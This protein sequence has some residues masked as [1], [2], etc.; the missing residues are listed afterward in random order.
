[1]AK[2]AEEKW[3]TKGLPM[4]E[5]WSGARRGVPVYDTW[6]D[7]YK[8]ELE[9]HR[10][11]VILD[12]GC[13]TGANTL[14]LVERGFQ[15]LSADYS[16]E[17]LANVR[18]YIPGSRTE[19]VDMNRT[20]PF[21]DESFHIIVADISLHYFAESATVSLMGEIRRA[22]KPGGLLLARVSSMNDTYYGAGSGREIQTHFYDHGSYAQ[23]YFDEGDV[24]RFF[25][26]IGRCTYME[27]SMTRKE[28]YYS[29]PKML[30]QVKAEKTQN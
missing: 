14:Y 26:I 2:A 30:Y 22:L 10:D 7:G 12:L 5:G 19:Y 21:R 18:R 6:L 27:T 4:W 11:S 16:R 23:R 24:E 9:R 13:G 28:A 29:H 20:F 8:E 15:V 3:N 25:G 17:A 1:M